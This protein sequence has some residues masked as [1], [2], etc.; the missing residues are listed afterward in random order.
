[1]SDTADIITITGNVATDPELKRTSAGMPIAS[2]RVAS[3]LR[4]YDRD[5]GTWSDVGTNW[6]SVSVFRTLA[7]HAYASIHKGDRVI[8]T[9]RL[10]VK[11]WDNGT[12]R[13]T[14]VE[15]EA[16]AI[17]HD[18]RW[19]TT[20]YHRSGRATS[21]SG[22]SEASQPTEADAWATPGVGAFEPADA[23]E[24]PRTGEARPLV[25]AGGGDAPAG[26]GVETSFGGSAHSWPRNPD[27]PLGDWRA[28]RRTV[29]V[30][31]APAGRL[32]G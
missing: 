13:G 29:V 17:G 30:L 6:F 9:G 25:L 32:G 28:H 27:S 14:S 16:D 3:G 24:P 7:E 1:M 22:E 23:H 19:G 8:L 11:D 2:F 15:I 5:S 12:R 31:R 18:L 26:M 20:T 21:P 10:R 4:R